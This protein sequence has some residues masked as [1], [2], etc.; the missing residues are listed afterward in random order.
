MIT[1]A[2]SAS[3]AANVKTMPIALR[4]QASITA[5]TSDESSPKSFIFQARLFGVP[6]ADPMTCARLPANRQ[7]P[8]WSDSISQGRLP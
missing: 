3:S 4:R 8:G 2:G 6:G 1:I 7:N 5:A